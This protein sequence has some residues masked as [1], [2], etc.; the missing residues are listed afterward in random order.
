MGRY[1]HGWLRQKKDKWVF[2]WNATRP[3]D[4]KKTERGRVIGSL[5]D[6]P[7]ESA[8]WSEVDRLG[9]RNLIHDLNAD[10][11]KVTFA[12]LVQYYLQHKDW[13]KASTKSRHTKIVHD[14]LLPRWGSRVAVEIKPREI[15]DWLRSLE[16]AEPTRYKYR[17]VMGSIFSF[18][19]A[20]DQL[21]LGEE[22]NPVHYVTG[23]ESGSD[24]EATVLTPE[25]T[26]A[27]LRELE[28]PEYEL[29]LLVAATG[30]RISEALGLRWQDLHFDK[31]EIRIRQTYV[32]GTVQSGAKTKASRSAVPMHPLLAE[33]LKAWQAESPY[34]GAEDYVFASTRLGGR[35]PRSSSIIVEDYLRPAAVKAGAIR[36]TE[37]GRTLD[38]RG[39]E[40]TRFGFHNFR[41]SLASFMI[42][43]GENPKIVQTILRHAKLDMTMYYSHSSA[44]EK[45]LAQ[46]RMLKRLVPRTDAVQ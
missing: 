15:K 39:D 37:D 8:A 16:V 44:G 4:G 26:L 6:F 21:P 46:E 13:K 30:L 9:L 34:S 24:Y 25:Q 33:S 27:V 18:C 36:M 2:C 10:R 17:T 40:I 23:I 29:T 3:E 22:N 7:S 19:Q 41:H 20:E 32:H 1:S 45:L 12:T 11:K 42:S 38:S 43:S 28:Q 35:K 31:N 14:I 5:Q